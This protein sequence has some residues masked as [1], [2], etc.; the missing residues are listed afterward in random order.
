MRKWIF[1]FVAFLSLNSL[2]LPSVSE[3]RRLTAS[4]A[5]DLFEKV[6]KAIQEDGPHEAQEILEK[7]AAN[8]EPGSVTDL[9]KFQLGYIYFLAGDY[10]KSLTQFSEFVQMKSKLQD[11]GYFYLAQNYLKLGKEHEA[12]EAFRKIQ[13][14]SPNMKLR[15][16]S[17]LEFSVLALK[18]KNYKEARLRLAALER[19]SRGTE[20]YPE[21][22]Y[23]LAVSEKGT[24]NSG[25]L[26]KWA[27]KLYEKYA[28]S[29]HIQD[30]GP[31]L[32]E[33][34]I[35]GVKTNCRVGLGSFKNRIKHLMWA[36]LDEKALGEINFMKSKLSDPYAADE[37]QAQFFL[38]E[39]EANKALDI[40]KNYHKSHRRNF[41]YLILY[42]GAAARAG[43][44]QVAVGSFYEAYK[45]SPR[46][47][48]GRQALYQS[49]FLSYQF[50]DYDGAG[51]RFREFLKVYPRSGLGRDAQWN[52]A[53]LQYLKGDFKGAF[54]SFSKLSAQKQSRRR[55]KV[56]DDRTEYWKAMSLYRLGKPEQAKPI[57]DRLSRD[58]LLG[59]YAIA[60][61]ARLKKM[62]A[63]KVLPSPLGLP[64]SESGRRITRFSWNEYLVVTPESESEEETV[65]ST[66][67]TESE[68][69]SVTLVQM[70][71]EEEG[72]EAEAETVQE[73]GQSEI[74]PEEPV[75]EFKSPMLA[76]RFEKARDLMILGL[77]DWAKWDLY[78][79][80]KKT[81]NKDYLRTLMNEY[82]TVEHYNRSAYLGHV[83]FSPSRSAQGIEGVRYLWEYAYPQAYSANVESAAKE[84]KIPQELIWGIMKA[85]SQFRRDAI[86]PVGALGLMQVMPITGHKVAEMLD[87]SNFKASQLLE[88]PT[89]IRIGSRYLQKLMQNFDYS[90]PFVAAAYNAGPHR[91]RTWLAFFGTLDVDEFVEH[92]PF[93]ETRN[94]VKKVISNS[95]VYNRL[96][97]ANRELPFYL[98]DPIKI[99]VGEPFSSKEL[100]D[101]I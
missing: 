83:V 89:A 9:V 13:K 22:L 55:K 26:C 61:Q 28:A 46:S 12:A 40:L 86:S 98:S 81:K 4:E 15:N 1:L 51:R 90:I 87:E 3:A 45:V 64:T 42:A 6:R 97:G 94:Y 43:D 67:E 62:E 96:Y 44:V 91:V 68:E 80:E 16:E 7:E 101:D 73:N 39:G 47:K 69:E 25:R 30:W 78:E 57:F 5:S 95:H 100:W 74:A 2:L 54:D 99:K 34:K 38:Q 48:Q 8:A 60:S 53:W 63:T 77:N 71:N 88:P 72:E 21:V 32:H 24:N 41:N 50:Q 35:D 23:N 14:M 76:Q 84:F 17:E 93:L 79:I 19:R 82:T 11:Y 52:L 29:T 92:I 65:A 27:K 20:A 10:E 37:L 33:N 85:E 18:K 75:S 49:A 66:E 56:S 31:E 58:R 59:Y 36:G 70:P